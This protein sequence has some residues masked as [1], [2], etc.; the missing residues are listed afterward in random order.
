MGQRDLLNYVQGK[1][2]VDVGIR[3]QY[4]FLNSKSDDIE[5]EIYMIENLGDKYLVKVKTGN[6]LLTMVTRNLNYKIGDKVGVDI[7][8]NNLL[9]F[10]K[11]SEENVLNYG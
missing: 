5:A 10:D 3:P 11:D 9:L 4:I 8:L 2:W 7:D 1:K 6:I